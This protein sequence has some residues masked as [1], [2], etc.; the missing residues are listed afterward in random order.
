MNAGNGCHLCVKD[1]IRKAQNSFISVVKE[2]FDKV[3][4]ELLSDEY[5]NQRVKLKYRC[6][7]HNDIIQEMDWAHFSRGNRCPLCSRKHM[8]D[9]KRTTWEEIEKEF[10][11]RGYT[12][13]PNQEYKTN[14]NKLKY[15][16][17]KHGEQ[18]IR[19]DSFKLGSGCPCCKES[20]GE[21]AINKW[22]DENNIIHAQE[23]TFDDLISGK[24]SKLRFDFA[25][26]DKNNTLNMLIEY[27]GEQHFTP[28]D[29]AGKG[30][31]WAEKN[32]RESKQRDI[33]KTNYCKE[34]GIKLVRISYADFSILEQIL[35]K[36]IL[37]GETIGHS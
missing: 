26:F 8:A 18:I 29:F 34:H 11:D 25:V 14:R 7:I 12:L 28:V 1:A 22:L 20:K 5:V 2:E 10:K 9:G 3:G 19:Y 6:P 23:F 31:A 15:I 4:Y 13:L 32:F 16:C 21:S 17:S 35:S 24:G 27:D 30:K 37:G 33:L 36:E